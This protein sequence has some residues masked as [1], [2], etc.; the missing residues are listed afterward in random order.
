MLEIK[1]RGVVEARRQIFGGEPS[2]EQANAFL[3]GFD[4]AW[5]YSLLRGYQEWLVVRLGGGY[6]IHWFGLGHRLALGIG[7]Y[8][9]VPEDRV[10]EESGAGVRVLESVIEFLDEVDQLDGRR[11]I[12]IRYEAQRASDGLS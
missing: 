10:G 12:Y 6:N 3:A 4:V 9:A 8:D 1:L 7:P 11:S 5:G 2:I